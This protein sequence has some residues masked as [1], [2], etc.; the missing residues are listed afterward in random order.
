MKKQR[1]EIGIL[2]ADDHPEFRESLRKALE[3]EPGFRVLGEAGDGEQTL[4][5]ARLAQAEGP[6]AEHPIAQIVGPRG[7]E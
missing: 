3:V 4:A 7:P 1:E 6:L 5:L 2:I